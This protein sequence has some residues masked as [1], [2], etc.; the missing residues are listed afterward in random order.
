MK[1]NENV[2]ANLDTISKPEHSIINPEKIK[3]LLTKKLS[4][5]IPNTQRLI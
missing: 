1:T 2:A 5:K 3:S 4:T